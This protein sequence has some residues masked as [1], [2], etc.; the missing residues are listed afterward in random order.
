MRF[1]SIQ[2]VIVMLLGLLLAS[3]SS[4]N[5]AVPVTDPVGNSSSGASS[6]NT[7]SGSSAGE[8]AAAAIAG[9]QGNWATPCIPEM[10][11]NIK[12]TLAVSE[13]NAEFVL[14]FFSDFN[15]T[16]AVAVD[17]LNNAHALAIQSV[18][19]PTG[20]LVS[21]SI[22]AATALDI[23]TVDVT[24]D[25]QPAPANLAAIMVPEV[26]H[27]I[28]LVEDTNLYFGDSTLAGFEGDSPATRPVSLD[29]NIVYSRVP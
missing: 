20:D 6:G 21:T 24:L 12:R 13:E 23:F 4:S 11:F 15:C 29:F 19:V 8:Q 3:C 16:E 14:A 7:A 9:I 18:T 26:R 22:G 10:G 2:I 17:I 25:G 1:T 28:V 27:T 5:G